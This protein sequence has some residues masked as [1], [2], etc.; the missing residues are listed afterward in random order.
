VGPE[1]SHELEVTV[2]PQG[3]SGAPQ[4]I[5]GAYTHRPWLASWDPVK[6]GARRAA[7]P[8]AIGAGVLLLL[9]FILLADVPGRVVGGAGAAGHAVSVTAARAWAAAPLPG[10]NAAAAPKAVHDC[11]LDGRFA[12]FTPTEAPLIGTCASRV[13][14]DP[15]GNAIQYTT[16][17]VL[18]WLKTT[19]SVYFFAGDSVYVLVDGR[20]RRLNG[21]GRR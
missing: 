15:F 1:R 11:A 2:R 20:F 3:A 16:N 17:G 5:R 19:D 21:S 10:R 8:V 9:A 14:S 12:G 18:Y 13:D 7:R 4:T 6:R